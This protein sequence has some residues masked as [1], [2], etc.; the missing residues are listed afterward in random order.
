MSTFAIGATQLV[1]HE[2]LEITSWRCGSYSPSLTP[3]TTV[4]SAS[5][6]G[7]DSSTLRA[8][9]QVQGRLVA[10]AELAGGLDH[11]VNSQ[12]APVDVGR[13]AAGQHPDRAAADDDRFVGVPTS[14]FRRP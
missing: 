11:D 10:G 5:L 12:P 8:P 1:V 7:A 6:P 13:I 9:L 2:A 14:A 4:R 3:T